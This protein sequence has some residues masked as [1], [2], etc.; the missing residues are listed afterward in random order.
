[1][2]KFE[3]R[4]IDN[5]NNIALEYDH[6]FDGKFTSK[7]K[8]LLLENM[9]V[10][11]G[12]SILDVACGNGSFLKMLEQQH[13]VN[14]YGVDISEEMIKQAQLK[15]PNMNF[16]VSGC[17]KLPFENNTI[18]II[19]VCAAFHH[20]PNVA[21]FFKEVYR[22]LKPNG[23][24]YMAEVYCVPVIRN[25]INLFMPLSKAGDVK[26]YSPKEIMKLSSKFR[27]QHKKTIKRNYIQLIELNKV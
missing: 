26:F 10:K 24:L 27:L 9:I 21:D 3:K 13:T 2:N 25:I 14:G 12:D 4:S 15:N 17:D 1:M 19:T 8:T 22:V 16:S 18:D 20:F 11:N 5:Y 6:T 7:F 23:K